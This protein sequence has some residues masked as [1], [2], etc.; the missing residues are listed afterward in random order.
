[1][2]MINTGKSF[3]ECR[4]VQSNKL[5]LDCITKARTNHRTTSS[6]AALA[7]VM[8]LCGCQPQSEPAATDE[9]PAADHEGD[10]VV[11]LPLVT[12]RSEMLNHKLELPGHVN[13]LPDHSVA[14]TSFITGKIDRL[15]VVP[16][17]RVKKGQLIAVLDDRQIRAQLQQALLP[18]ESAKAAVTQAESEHKFAKRELQRLQELYN[19]DIAAK[20][21]VLAQENLVETTAAK[22]TAARAK[23]EEA[24]SATSDE[25]TQLKFTQIL[26]P[27]TGLVAERF[28]NIG[29]EARPNAPIV[30]LVNL[31][32]VV[33][34][35]DAPADVPTRVSPGQK[36]IVASIAEPEKPYPAS[37]ISISPTVDAQ[38]NTIKIRLQCTNRS[39]GLKE[40]QTVTVTIDSGVVTR[41][42]SIPR[43]AIV[44]DPDDSKRTLVYV[45]SN[46]K[47]KRVPV[48]TGTETTDQVEIT[49]GLHPGDTII[50]KGSYGLPEGVTVK[51]LETPHE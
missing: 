7:A 31:S 15:L 25:E 38:K 18:I 50:A 26:S 13:A 48:T 8:I 2:K 28:L 43:T 10:K 32:E 40:G 37:I 16:G 17:Q 45:V 47:S 36:A 42:I 23:L 19:N 1:M 35:A 34:D 5:R 44:P 12:V 51:P 46:G 29:D 22:L 6:M 11:T 20:K 39:E 14:V 30:H 9:A 33:V 49:T 27:I 41:S 21:D 4:T 3:I 24:R